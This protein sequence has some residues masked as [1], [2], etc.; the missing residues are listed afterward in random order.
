MKKVLAL[1]S[2]LLAL[3]ACGG[4]DNPTASITGVWELSSVATKASVGSETVNVYVEFASSGNFTLYQKIGGGRYTKFTGS[5]TYASGSLSG[6]YSG[7][8]SWG[9]YTVSLDSSTLKLSTAGEV[10]TY[11]KIDA[12]PAS[13]ISNTY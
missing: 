6:K 13:V 11:R 2:L 12:V 4:K 5:Y 7:G 1:T 9:P 3:A 8:A 10:D